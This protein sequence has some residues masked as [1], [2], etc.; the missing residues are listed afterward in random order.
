MIQAPAPTTA[1]TAQRPASEGQGA[2]VSV[3]VSLYNYATEIEKCLDSV[4]AQDHCRLELIVV[5]DASTDTSA[6]VTLAWLGLNKDRFERA[7]LLSQPRNQGLSAARNQA[8]EAAKADYVFVL[9]A[10][11]TLHPPAIS[12][13]LEVL[14]DTG[15]AVAYSQ[16]VYFGELTSFGVANLWRAD[17]F[18]RDNYI[19]AMALVRKSAWR[20]VGGYS[21][22]DYGWEDYDLWCKFVEAGLKGVYVPEPLCRYRVHLGSM[23]HTDTASERVR[24]VHSMMAAHPW[25]E[26]TI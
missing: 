7:A 6:A 9:D 4:K 19:D 3:I 21:P 16:L 13:L 20:E 24:L 1:F 12:R 17:S 23:R 25:L 8:F 10:D 5:D 22:M 15:A 11:N 26:L 14:E 18:K 2:L